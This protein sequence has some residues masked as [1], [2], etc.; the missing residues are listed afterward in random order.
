MNEE[1]VHIPTL[2]VTEGLALSTRM[3]RKCIDAETVTVNGVLI[4]EYNLPASQLKGAVIKVGT[5]KIS[6]LAD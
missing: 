4:T 3:A 1:Q 6:H 5:R 2:L